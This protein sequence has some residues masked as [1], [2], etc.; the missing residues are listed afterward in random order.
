[1]EDSW[2]QELEVF[3]RHHR[4]IMR[5]L[6]QQQRELAELNRNSGHKPKWGGFPFSLLGRA[7]DAGVIGLY[8]LVRKIVDTFLR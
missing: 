6:D 7:V 2:R 3:N 5:L 8:R 4:E 1:M